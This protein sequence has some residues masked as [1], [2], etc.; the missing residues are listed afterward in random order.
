ME[1]SKPKSIFATIFSFASWWICVLGATYLPKSIE[2]PFFAIFIVASL[3]VHWTWLLKGQKSFW[4][5]YTIILLIGILGDSLLFKLGFFK[6]D[7]FRPLYLPNWL[8]S[9]WVVFPLC[10][11]HAWKKVT[12]RFLYALP[13]GL[14]GAPLAYKAGPSFGILELGENALIAVSIFWFFYMGLVVILAKKMLGESSSSH[15]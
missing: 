4:A 11:G 5:F 7:G 15:S 13:I 3:V 6:A 10:F 12:T 1:L 2:A 9:I 8:I 14:I